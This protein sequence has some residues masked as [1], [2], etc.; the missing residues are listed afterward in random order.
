MTTTEAAKE[1]GI[2]AMYLA[3]LCASGR[4]AAKKVGR[5]WHIT[6]AA[7][8]K[9]K[10]GRRGA[11]RPR[12]ER[13]GSR[14][15]TLIEL[16]VAVSVCAVLVGILIPTLA[17]SREE[18]RKARCLSDLKNLAVPVAFYVD[19]YRKLPDAMYAPDELHLFC[20]S[21]RDPDTKEYRFPVGIGTSSMGPSPATTWFGRIQ[22]QDPSKVPVVGC[23]TVV[24]MQPRHDR[25]R[26]GY[27][28]GGAR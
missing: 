24:V 22:S 20:P 4:I 16:L 1:L 17:K 14:A 26:F 15:F 25:F 6:A 5:D 23:L 21:A 27:L 13:K 12:K 3:Q 2:R 19:T 11:G 28:D 10:S 8:A 7:L 18:A 9:F